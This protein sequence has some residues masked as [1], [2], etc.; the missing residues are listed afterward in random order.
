MI[1][2]LVDKQ[3]SP[4]LKAHSSL[5]ATCA[6]ALKRPIDAGRRQ[7]LVQQTQLTTGQRRKKRPIRDE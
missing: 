1:A 7:R 2:E 5:R 6:A 3:D 4:A